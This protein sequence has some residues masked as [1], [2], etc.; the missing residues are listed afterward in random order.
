VELR[1]R[2]IADP[3]RKSFCLRGTLQDLTDR[4]RIE[5]EL[6][7]ARARLEI[8]Q[9]SAGIGTF[10]YDLKSGRHIWTDQLLRIYG[11]Q[12]RGFTERYEDWAARVHEEDRPRVDA[13]FRDATRVERLADHWRVVRPDGSV[14]WVEASGELMASADGTG[15]RMIGVNIDITHRKRAEER[16]TAL[17][18][19]NRRLA[20]RNIELLEAERRY[21]ARELHDEMGQQVTAIHMDAGL[22]KN[23]CPDP[24]SP[25]HQYAL[26]IERVARELIQSMRAVTNQLRPTNLD[27]LGL[28]A[29]LEEGLGRWGEQHA[30]VTLS[31]AFRG[32]VDGLGEPLNI[33]LFRIVQE[34]LTNISRHAR[35]RRV[36]VRL[37]RLGAG[38]GRDRIVLTVA[39][40]GVGADLAKR[41]TGMGIPGMRERAQSLG[42]TFR[43]LSKHRRGTEVEVIVPLDAAAAS[44]QGDGP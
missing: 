35:A 34:C 6:R 1:A 33:T 31:Y 20:H 21:L 27:V 32:D 28:K 5:A 15:T 16:I 30:G 43:I 41:A 36:N 23:A 37:K 8:A 19:E 40:D 44:G 13:W 10:E 25:V 11:I 12:R 18:E 26:D 22:I 24:E 38:T 14:R 29:T 4:W 9:Q 17:L 42:G 3:R 7:A 2:R 39:D